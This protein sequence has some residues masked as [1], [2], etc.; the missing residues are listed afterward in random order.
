MLPVNG[1][2]MISKRLASGYA[3]TG[4]LVVPETTHFLHIL[5]RCG[6]LFWLV[7]GFECERLHKGLANHL[8]LSKSQ[9][10]KKG[11]QPLLFIRQLS[12]SVNDCLL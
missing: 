11:G 5:T 12:Y 7:K 6:V 2:N 8:K 4:V 9:L 3:G 10:K 1:A